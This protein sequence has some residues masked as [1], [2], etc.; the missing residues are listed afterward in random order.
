MTT[1]DLRVGDVV[2]MHC[3]DIGARCAF[4]IRDIKESDGC[5]V[6]TLSFEGLGRKVQ[7]HMRPW[8][9]NPLRLVSWIENVER[10]GKTLYM[11]ARE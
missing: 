5:W 8:K 3:S 9:R 6:L 7:C 10:Q 2:V 4:R 11:R 1:D